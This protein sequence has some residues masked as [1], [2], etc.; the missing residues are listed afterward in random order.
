MTNALPSVDSLKFPPPDLILTLVELCFKDVNGHIPVLH[1]PSFMQQLR[2]ERHRTDIDFAKLLLAV[3]GLG[4]RYC[5]DP[6]VCLTS[7]DGEVEWGSAG[8]VYF[9][10][11]YGMKRE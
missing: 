5:K 2:E 10:Q 6:R 1:R 3:C 11:V 9:A 8:W 4:A 7:P